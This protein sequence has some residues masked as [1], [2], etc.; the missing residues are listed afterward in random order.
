MQLMVS[1]PNHVWTREGLLTVVWGAAD[2]SFPRT[3]DKHVETLRHKL[4]PAAAYIKTV[5]GVGYK[6]DE[7]EESK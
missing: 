1:R 4:G 7:G 6:F 2:K 3:V 5:P